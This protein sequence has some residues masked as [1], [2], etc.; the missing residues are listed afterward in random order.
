MRSEPA[1]VHRRASVRLLAERRREAAESA[2]P[3]TPVVYSPE[4]FSPFGP[5]AGVGFGTPFIPGISPQT[6]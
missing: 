1:I 2:G 6:I 5:A 4:G 3:A